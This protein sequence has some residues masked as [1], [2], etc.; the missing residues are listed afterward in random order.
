[1]QIEY[2]NFKRSK[3]IVRCKHV[4]ETNKSTRFIAGVRHRW[5]LCTNIYQK[6]F[7]FTLFTMN[8]YSTHLFSLLKI[9]GK[10]FIRSIDYVR[11]ISVVIWCPQRS[12]TKNIHFKALEG[13]KLLISELCN[14][15]FCKCHKN[16]L[17]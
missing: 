3:W 13:K 16:F 7:F 9:N 2:Q 8:F 15:S 4:L 14:P 10:N 12:K 17:H 5:R 6:I 1:M 11:M